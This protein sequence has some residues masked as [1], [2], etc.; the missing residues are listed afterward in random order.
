MSYIDAKIEKLRQEIAEL[1]TRKKDEQ[2]EGVILRFNEAAKCSANVE[3]YLPQEHDYMRMADMND[4]YTM[5]YAEFI[6]WNLKK[7][8]ELSEEDRAWLKGLCRRIRSDKIRLMDHESCVE[9]DACGFYYDVRGHLCI[10]HP[11]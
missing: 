3:Y 10:M 2:L 7:I 6:A 11:R 9:W 5:C 1:E 4:D 8:S